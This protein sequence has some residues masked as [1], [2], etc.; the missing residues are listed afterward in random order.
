[1]IRARILSG[2]ALCAMVP[3]WAQSTVNAQSMVGAWLVSVDGIPDNETRTLIIA[4]EAGS[5]S[6]AELAAKYGLTSKGKTPVGAKITQDRNPRQLIVITQAASTITVDEAPD[7]S[8]SGSFVSKAG[9]SYPVR[10]V[11]VTE[12]Q[13]AELRPP[14]P[15]ASSAAPPCASFEG[16]WTGV[17]SQ[18]G[19]GQA[20]LWVQAPKANC[21]TRFAYLSEDREPRGWSTGQIENGSLTFTCN[22]TTAGVCT[23]KQVGDELWVSYSGNLGGNNAVFRRVTT[24]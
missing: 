13:L 16:R 5:A 14:A 24:R 7:G 21:T 2:L 18:G 4:S 12:A 23:F 6:S 3:A 20:W 10:V 22:T 1:M 17:W 19:R 11:R 15:S 9:K 8:F